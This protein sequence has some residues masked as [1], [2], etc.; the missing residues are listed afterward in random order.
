MKTS[1]Y[2][3]QWLTIIS[4]MCLVAA[5][6]VAVAGCTKLKYDIFKKHDISACEVKDP[7]QN[8]EWLRKYCESFDASQGLSSVN[9]YLYKVIDTEEHLFKVSIAYPDF[10]HSPVLYSEEWR[11]CAGELVFNIVSAVPP[12][13]GVVEEFLKDKEYVDELF[14]FVKR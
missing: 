1:F 4:A 11:N 14:H 5:T 13:P 2:K 9:I 7:L 6:L 10:E 12:M 8:I 3:S